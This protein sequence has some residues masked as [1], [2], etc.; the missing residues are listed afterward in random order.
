MADYKKM[1]A[2]LCGAVDDAISALEPYPWSRTTM[3]AL[4]NAKL[5]AEEVY[6]ETT[7]YIEELDGKKTVELTVDSS[8]EAE[9]A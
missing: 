7:P 5:Q 2:I 6:I 3:R 8:P 4:Q 9:E 1:Y